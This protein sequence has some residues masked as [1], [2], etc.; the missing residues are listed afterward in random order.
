MSSADAPGH[1]SASPSSSGSSR[2]KGVPPKPEDTLVYLVDDEPAVTRTLGR[3]LQNQGYELESFTDPI[4]ARARI[5]DRPPAV[6]LTDKVMPTVD[7]LELAETALAADP[8]TAVIIFTGSGDVESAAESVRMGISD[9]LLKPVDLKRLEKAL[10]QAVWARTMRRYRRD[11]EQWL[12]AE[13]Q[14]RTQEVA[15]QKEQL[16][17]LTVMALSTLVRA[18]ET[19]SPYFEGHSQAVSRLSHRMALQMGLPKKEGEAFRSGGY[20]HDI[21]MIA[22]PDRILNKEGPLSREEFDEVKKHS[23]LG[24]DILRPFTHLGPVRQFVLR[25]HERIDGSGYPDGLQGDEIPLGAQIVGAADA[26]CA[27]MEDRPYRP[28]SSPQEALETLTGTEGIWF[29]RKVL[30]VLQEALYPSGARRGP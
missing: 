17:N 12:R 19:K 28:A 18:M 13:I 10:T 8:D 2:P 6:L 23:R 3:Y 26:Y 29:S 4:A 20:L 16:E 9:Y 30:G 1:G 11:T 7:G 15:R 22:V 21:G 5:E 14:A 27:L 24:E 25:H